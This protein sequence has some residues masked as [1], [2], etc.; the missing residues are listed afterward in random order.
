M[1]NERPP[2][3]SV[4]SEYP[5]ASYANSQRP[6][7]PATQRARQEAVVSQGSV[8]LR[9]QSAWKRARHKIVEENGQTLMSYILN[10]VVI[11]TLKSTFV[12][13]V[14]NGAD[15]M[16]YGEA[17]HGRPTINRT[18]GATRIIGGSRNGGPYT[19][20]TDISS[21]RNTIPVRT[22]QTSAAGLRNRLALDDFIFETRAAANDVLDRMSTLIDDYG[23][24]SVLNLYDF[25]GLTCPFTYDDYVWTDLSTVSVTAVRDG[26]LLNLPTPHLKG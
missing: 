15:I 2:I 5:N 18:S 24:V 1:E 21:S 14:S 17:R 16:V 10:D 7:P 20:Y 8:K 26:W 6:T 25:C 22:G 9:K 3:N 12:D 13:V 11:P 4:G 19:T 23:M